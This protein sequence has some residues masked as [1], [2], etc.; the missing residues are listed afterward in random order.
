MMF[1]LFPNF[2]RSAPM[3]LY[4]LS[5]HR[6]N[7]F[8]ILNY[9][10]ESQHLQF[11]DSQPETPM[12]SRYYSKFIKRCDDSLIKLENLSE[13]MQKFKITLKKTKGDVSEFLKELHDFIKSKNLP[14]KSYLDEVE[15]EIDENH[16]KLQIQIKTFEDLTEKRNLLHEHKIS[17]IHAK[18]FIRES[19]VLRE[20]EM[21]L[22]HNFGEIGGDELKIDYK[23]GLI[24]KEDMIRFKRLIFRASKGNAIVYL[25]ELKREENPMDSKTVIFL[26]II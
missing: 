5:L 14:E 15:S 2:L 12:Y 10:G 6:E 18:S 3:N 16:V 20:A 8:D 24:L 4:S 19:L 23:M 26:C 7:S 11:L 21:E 9:L 25:E 22:S 1:S 17:M 13:I